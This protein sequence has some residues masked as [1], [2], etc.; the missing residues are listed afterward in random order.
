MKQVIN[1]AVALTLAVATIILIDVVACLL[2]KNLGA[3]SKV[4]QLS[5]E[6]LTV[7]VSIF[8]FI[9]TYLYYKE[10]MERLW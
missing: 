5:L 10:K 4:L 8:A 7:G 9:F 1:K 3:S 2:L 6:C